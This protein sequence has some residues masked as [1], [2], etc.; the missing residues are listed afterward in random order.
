MAPQPPVGHE[1]LIVEASRSNSDTPQ[2]V[3]L[4]WTSDQYDAQISDNTQH[5][6]ETDIY[7]SGGIRTRNPS[8]Q[9]TAD[10]RL[11]QRGHW[12]RIIQA[13]AQYN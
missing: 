5:S 4:P 12:D 1:L 6:Q 9:E 2:S 8:N 7:A 13:I 3:G 10:P 11:R